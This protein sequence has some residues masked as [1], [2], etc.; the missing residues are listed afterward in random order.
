MWGRRHRVGGELPRQARAT[1]TRPISTGASMS[2]PTTPD[3]AW[4]Q[5]TPKAAM[6]TAM[7]GSKVLAA[8]VNASV[9]VRS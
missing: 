2:G 7:A 1:W 3:R 6:A 8:A 9:A 5:V 4:P